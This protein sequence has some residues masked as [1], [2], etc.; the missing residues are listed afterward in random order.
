MASVWG[1]CLNHNSQTTYGSHLAQRKKLGGWLNSFACFEQ[2]VNVN[3]RFREE[4]R[5]EIMVPAE[6]YG[7]IQYL[8]LH[9]FEGEMHALVYVQFI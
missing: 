2:E 8:I 5:G 4:T 9:E 1:H 7:D 6:Y 3:A